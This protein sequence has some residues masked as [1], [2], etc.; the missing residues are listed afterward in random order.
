MRQAHEGHGARCAPS[1]SVPNC[2]QTN[3]NTYPYHICIWY[4]RIVASVEMISIDWVHM[5]V[6][7]AMTSPSHTVLLWPGLLRT[8]SV[9]VSGVNSRSP[10]DRRARAPQATTP[11]VA[12]TQRTRCEDELHQSDTDRMSGCNA[13]QGTNP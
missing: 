12:P 10:I 2:T 5:H 11:S 9:L 3:N 7:T 8:S 1:Y 13:P 4:K 6:C